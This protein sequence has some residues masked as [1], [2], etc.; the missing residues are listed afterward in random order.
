MCGVRLLWRR[1]CIERQKPAAR[2]ARKRRRKKKPCGSLRFCRWAGR[3]SGT[4]R[5][6]FS[7]G[8]A[9]ETGQA[10]QRPVA[11]QNLISRSSV[12]S[13]EA[14]SNFQVLT[15]VTADSANRG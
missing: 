8:N 10:G 15:A 2:R 4:E 3:P 12:V 14:G 5:G 11:N 1:S 9:D 6:L 7:F 13:L